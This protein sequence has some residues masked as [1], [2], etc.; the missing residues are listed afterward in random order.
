MKKHHPKAA[1]W[2]LAVLAL[3][4]SSV[5][6]AQTYITSDEPESGKVYRLMN[7]N[8]NTYYLKDNGE[9]LTSFSS[10]FFVE[11]EA[12]FW[13]FTK[14]D[15]GNWTVQNTSTGRY[16]SATIAYNTNVSTSADVASVKVIKNGCSN[17]NATHF[18]ITSVGNTSYSL[19]IHGGNS[20]RVIGWNVGD[21]TSATNSEW[22]L[23]EVDEAELAALPTK[24]QGIID[25]KAGFVRLVSNRNSGDVA[26]A[27]G[28]NT[29]VRAKSA[30]TNYA[31]IW[32]IVPHGDGYA[33][34]NMDSDRY[35]QAYVAD[36]QVITL[37][38]EPVTYYISPSYV[39]G[40][41]L[42]SCAAD[43]SGH[44]CLH[45][46]GYNKVVGWDT[47]STA[48]VWALEPLEDEL[49]TEI[50][51]TICMNNFAETL[52]AKGGLVQLSP[53]NAIDRVMESHN[54]VAKANTKSAQTKYS[55]V[56]KLTAEGDG[57][58]LRNMES[59]KYLQAYVS[60][61]VAL[62]LSDS[63][64]TFYIKASPVAG[65][66]E[67][68]VVISSTA[69]YSAHTCLHKAGNNNV[70]G[71]EVNN[72]NSSWTVTPAE[73]VTYRDYE[74]QMATLDALASS[75]A[76]ATGNYVRFVTDRENGYVIEEDENHK[77]RLRPFEQG[78]KHQMWK[79]A[80]SG[81]YYTIRNLATGYYIDRATGK[82]TSLSAISSTRAYRIEYSAEA[83]ATK[84]LFNFQHQNATTIG[85]YYDGTSDNLQLDDTGEGEGWGF[86]MEPVADLPYATPKVGTI[87]RIQN[88][89]RL[90][91]I[92]HD[93]SNT[94]SP[95]R[96]V[97]S[98]GG[99][100]QFWQLIASNSGTG[101]MLK[102]IS[103]GKYIA[104]AGARDTNYPAAAEGGVFTF[105]AVEGTPYYYIGET[106]AQ[107][108]HAGTDG[109]VLRFDFTDAASQWYLEEA[110][111]GEIADPFQ[112]I[113]A[114]NDG[115]VR[116]I[117]NRNSAKSA[118]DINGTNT[119]MAARDNS[120][121]SQIWQITPYGEG[122]ALKNMESDQYLQGFV[123]VRQPITLADALVTYYIKPSTQKD[124]QYVLSS[125]SDYSGYTC[126]HDD[127]GNNRIVGWSIDADVSQW[128]I[129]AV[130]DLT[131][132]QIQL[133]KQKDVRLAE[134]IAANNG[135][136]RIA[137][138]RT[139]G[140][141]MADGDALSFAAPN[142]GD[143]SQLWI[144]TDSDT[145][146]KL[147]NVQ[148]GG[149]VSIPT[150]MMTTLATAASSTTVNIGV[151]ANATL[152]NLLFTITNPD[153]ERVGAYYRSTDGTVITNSTAVTPGSAF[154][155]TAATGITA[156]E[157]RTALLIAEGFDIPETG[158]YYRI[159]NGYWS[160]TQ[161]RTDEVITEEGGKLTTTAVS[162]D[163]R[164][165]V[166]Q[167]IS[168]DGTNF[169]FKNL[170]T[171][172]YIQSQTESQSNGQPERY[173]TG[174]TSV[175]F[176]VRE[177]ANLPSPLQ[178]WYNII[179][180][181]GNALKMENH[182]V[183]DNSLANETTQS[184]WRFKEVD[185]NIFSY[186]TGHTIKTIDQIIDEYNGIVM[187]RSVRN[188]ALSKV[189]AP[190]TTG[191]G[192]YIE[193]LADDLTDKA[194]WN[195]LWYL[196]RTNSASPYTYT[197]RNLGSGKYITQDLGLGENGHNF[198]IQAAADATETTKTEGTFHISKE[199]T[200][201]GSSN[202]TSFNAYQNG[203]VGWWH[204]LNDDGSDWYIEPVSEITIEQ[205]RE[206]LQI[207]TY[208][209]P[210]DG[211]YYKIVSHAY[212]DVMTV[213]PGGSVLRGQADE[214]LP[215]QW[216]KVTKDGTS[217]NFQNAASGTYIQGDPGQ[218]NYFQ[219]G[220]NAVNFQLAQTG[221]HYG[222]HISG[223]GRGLHQSASQSDNIVSW[224]YTANASRWYF[225][226]V[227]LSE[228]E[229]LTE[230]A[231]FS[232]FFNA[233]NSA[234]ELSD[235][236]LQFFSDASATKLKG[237]Y[238]AMTDEE[239][240]AAMSASALPTAL[241]EEAVKVKNN[242]W[243]LWEREF[244]VANYRVFSDANDWHG[245]LKT[246][247]WGVINNPTGVVAQNG[248]VVYV[249]VGSDIPSNATLTL[250]A[251]KDYTVNNGATQSIALQ[252][253]LNAMSISNEASH[254]YVRYE[255]KY[256]TELANYPSL[257]IH[258]IGGG[259]NGYVDIAKH[260]DADWVNMRD[261]GLFWAGEIDLLGNYAQMHIEATGARNNGD[262]IRPII[263]LFD[264]YAH[265]QL[266]IMGLTAVPDS[267]KNVAGASDAY[268]DLYP[269]K[270]NNRLL[271]IGKPGIGLYG[272]AY[273]I[274]LGGDGN[275]HYESL[276]ARDAS[277]WAPAHEYGHV[278][279]GAIHLA[280]STEVSN[281]FYSNMTIYRGGN[282]TSRGWNMQ[283]M[284]R[285]MA[286]GNHKWPKICTM[287]YWLPT[288][289]YYSLYL[290]YHAAGNDPLFYQKLFKLL[291][292]NPL[293]A[294]AGD[295]GCTGDRD[296]LHFACMASDAAGEDLSDFFEYWGFFAPVENETMAS[297]STWKMT[298]TQEMID[299]AK[300]Y[301]AR[302]N[303][304][305]NP[306]M[307][308]IDDRS[309]ESYKPDGVTPKDPFDGYLV[310]NCQT[311]FPGAQYTAFQKDGDAVSH[312]N[313][314]GLAYTISGNTVTLNTDAANMTEAAGIKLYDETGKLVYIASQTEFTI[315]ETL[316]SSV[317]HSK[318]VISL[319]DGTTMPLYNET[320]ADIHLM[321]IH[322]SKGVTTTRYTKGG[323]DAMLN[324]ERD[325]K[326]A[327]AML[328]GDNVPESISSAANVAVNNTLEH[329]SLTDMLDFWVGTS[330][331]RSAVGLTAKKISYKERT[332]YEG[333]NTLCLPFAI[334]PADICDGARIEVLTKV[335]NDVLYFEEATSV[336]AGQPCIVNVPSD[337]PWEYSRENTTAVD[338][339]AT[340]QVSAN[341]VYMN[342][343]FV[344]E[345]IGEGHYKMNAD[346]TAFGRTTA[347]GKNFPFRAYLSTAEP[348]SASRFHAF[349]FD[350][351]TTGLTA[352]TDE[353]T[354]QDNR[355]C[356]DLQGR[357]VKNPKR[358]EIYILGGK[359]IMFK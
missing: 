137:T 90:G 29:M 25:S 234:T 305:C 168:T 172:N 239:L 121:F 89:T 52:A 302:H 279:Q 268:E 80:K 294:P 91:Y 263:G 139:S 179:S 350:S 246:N 227:N 333:W 355:T 85:W 162:S 208:T 248:D 352:P 203:T 185:P 341:D 97:T 265:C 178:K 40:K 357:K 103:T 326:N 161:G 132:E 100:A 153:N 81:N 33:L 167:L 74:E 339:A 293:N 101:Y 251:R 11:T 309:V 15:D 54:G 182:K 120:K 334:T 311:D 38:T 295:G 207:P 145:G 140:Y 231:E 36:N 10:C 312:S 73:G 136:V 165:E 98:G 332:L 108:L 23:E 13:R 266:D 194:N 8:K 169:S 229:I 290:Y 88:A 308:F 56:W 166:W 160:S 53:S 142:D 156:E 219:L 344:E 174:T 201:D 67:T 60:D 28:T 351:N 47:N 154:T 32:R 31:Q 109:D 171:G 221:E 300:D 275:F 286:E 123:Q 220:E 1:R 347:A 35:M 192:F 319:T 133:R 358:G 243:E 164:A 212:G 277:V 226:E 256:N 247:A 57:Y 282:A 96:K 253:G 176:P 83:T 24:L 76:A 163:D 147:Q 115:L 111:A 343:G 84:P 65:K 45:D 271:A 159:Y 232:E 128:T 270:V 177:S 149:Y 152:D 9:R 202:G 320:D 7:S 241:Q 288:Q 186:T 50:L 287:T 26:Q 228:E 102:N 175:T 285:H 329:L 49:I 274:G 280:A 306:S 328:S 173:V 223:N 342:G 289:M 58:T 30:E 331:A 252:K 222:I 64:V 199:N 107:G 230:A 87:Y 197:F 225:A 255:A 262:R 183:V 233:I 39:I 21:G 66:T 112:Q 106:D 249:V 325:G 224:D 79:V 27:E 146:Y 238:Q 299:D 135:L 114:T 316:A 143:L 281:N 113:L 218:G 19:N 283:E 310:E 75:L 59:G 216:W 264:W 71:W 335:E 353:E 62:T 359:K 209:E 93:E 254:I 184:N 14:L 245:P 213:Q 242:T 191:D 284:Q 42:I 338:V 336:D 258:I 250:E 261:N 244:R 157:V 3:L 340:A 17:A 272:G 330:N 110:K 51:G 195:Q 356:Y 273:H 267:L 118:A 206:H 130:T 189:M 141:V 337:M 150:T 68:H 72:V 144:M 34:R 276:K 181:G 70:V 313:P 257:N 259:V 105:T 297:Y 116:L 117:G 12:I 170:S 63:P 346:G 158:K 198:Y 324:S 193:T 196:E 55:Q 296:Y 18:N 124:G 104:Y 46:N 237:N 298:T 37:G 6:M 315:P 119:I 301:M 215:S 148:T 44:K 303:K 235:D 61:D 327:I 217:Y 236:Y 348:V 323:D 2:L 187:I 131:L 211:K 307:V 94:D 204:A 126:L 41:Y 77:L 190:K 278:N 291:R 86:A 210:E 345:T 240:R 188:G 16:I 138:D 155:I 269:K 69:D 260:S 4:C 78:N 125:T 134:I 20:D 354:E 5:T 127:S 318:T 22:K 82:L 292:A 122:Y 205:V 314:N 349:H 317:D 200:F 151:S 95:I 214:G 304:K 321:T 322:H 180:T 99:D 92:I 43:F 48:S 129:E